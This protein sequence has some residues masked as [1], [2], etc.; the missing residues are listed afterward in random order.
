MG[1][2]GERWRRNAR[3]GEEREEKVRVKAVHESQSISNNPKFE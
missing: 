1:A 2:Q 3:G